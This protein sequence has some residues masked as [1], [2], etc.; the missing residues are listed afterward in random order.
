MRSVSIETK[1]ILRIGAIFLGC[2]LIARS[3]QSDIVFHP[4]S[5]I[6]L[7]DFGRVRLGYYSCRSD[8]TSYFTTVINPNQSAD[9]H[10]VSVGTNGVVVILDTTIPS[11]TSS[12]ILSDAPDDNGVTVLLAGAPS[13]TAAPELREANTFLARYD[14]DGNFVS[15][16][17]LPANFFYHKIARYGV[18]FLALR[19]DPSSGAISLA[20][21]SPQGKLV[22]V[23]NTPHELIGIDEG[24]T[25]SKE[26]IPGISNTSQAFQMGLAASSIQLSSVGD[27]VYLIKSARNHEVYIVQ[28]DG[29]VRVVPLKVPEGVDPRAIFPDPSLGLVT[30]A[31]GPGERD[32]ALLRF[33]SATGI[34]SGQL[35][36]T[37]LSPVS[38]MCRRDDKFY[39]VRVNQTGQA[40]LVGELQQSLP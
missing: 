7:Q 35:K 28:K 8:G 9:T 12:T 31:Y 6:N 10:L 34:V 16:T 36:V 20:A 29:T 25:L 2:T 1:Q 27:A 26:R 19:T 13:K 23:I 4:D 32:S 24:T 3:Q 15:I 39:G 14:L 38:V 5:A 30:I 21:V 33:D 22:K 37:G 11:L 17:P 40:L 18:L